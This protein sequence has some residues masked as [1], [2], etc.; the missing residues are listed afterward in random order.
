MLR[1]YLKINFQTAQKH[2]KT[3][4]KNGHLYTVITCFSP[5]TSTISF[6]GQP[7]KFQSAIRALFKARSVQQSLIPV[8]MNSCS[9]PTHTTEIQLTSSA[10][11]RTCGHCFC[12]SPDLQ[13]SMPL[14][15]TVHH[16]SKRVNGNPRG[17]IWGILVTMS[18][19][20]LPFL[21]QY[22]CNQLLSGFYWCRV[23]NVFH[24][25]FLWRVLVLIPSFK[26]LFVQSSPKGKPDL[27]STDCVQRVS[28]R[29]WMASSASS[30]HFAVMG[31]EFLVGSM[32]G[33]S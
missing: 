33:N 11:P 20:I 22:N 18:K 15:I 23:L 17:S 24:L 14:W 29:P 30:N 28:L 9:C 31:W 10:W 5:S 3:N 6:T 27:T 26:Y 2:N 1:V 16:L 25:I 4:K 32:S 13:L 7:M 19:S 12:L 8:S 21:Q